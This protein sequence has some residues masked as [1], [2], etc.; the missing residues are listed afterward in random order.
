MLPLYDQQSL[1]EKLPR[2]GGPQ[3]VIDGFDKFILLNMLVDCLLSTLKRARKVK[4]EEHCNQVYGVLSMRSFGRVLKKR[5]ISRIV[6]EWVH[7]L[8]CPIK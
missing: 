7:H 4:C 5:N 6:L 8:Q 3:D 1:G 2:S